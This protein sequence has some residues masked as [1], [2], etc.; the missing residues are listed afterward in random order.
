MRTT[1]LY[2]IEV[3][4]P[5]GAQNVLLSILDKLN[6]GKYH[7]IVALI[8]KGWLEET[9]LSKGYKVIIVKS[10][11]KSFDW[12]LV[13]DLLNISKENNVKIIHAHLFDSGIYASIVG[14]LARIPIVITLHGQVDWKLSSYP[15]ID[16]IKLM[17]M[18]KF[19]NR[20]VYVS[21]HLKEYYEGLGV[22]KEI[23]TVIY[24]GIDL[25]VFYPSHRGNIRS[26]MGFSSKDILIGTIGHI[27]PWRG[28][29][30]LIEAA[31]IVV[32]LYPQTRFLIVGDK[33][34]ES[35]YQS[36]INEIEKREL[37]NNVY[38]LGF[39]TDVKEILAEIDL[40]VLPSLS[41][42]FSLSIIE[43]M[44]MNVPVI[45][46][47]CGGP[48]EIIE[49]NSTGYLVA[50]NDANALGGKIVEILEKRMYLNEVLIRAARKSVEERFCIDNQIA[51]YEQLY[52]SISN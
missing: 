48:E 7:P 23:G 10:R 26:A 51:L 8:E 16:K 42:G 13:K 1:I 39:R 14:F 47:K 44:A 33:G 15:I 2:L 3:S 22:K 17:I 4:C 49:D 6:R 34:I 41:E 30:F 18:N 36:L 21:K 46:T 25:N 27:K 35:Y 40:F 52:D 19:A 28:Y 38:F 11:R 29:E 31:E 9:L 32:K 43:A 5:G 50:K 12:K 24:N 20:V 45:A 37:Q